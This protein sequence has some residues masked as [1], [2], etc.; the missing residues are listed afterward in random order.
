MEN[1]NEQQKQGQEP[2]AEAKPVMNFDK[3]DIDENKLIAALSYLGL[4]CLIPL[5][6]KKDSKFAQEH[7]K[8]GLVLL[9][10]WMVIWVV[11]IIPIL[12]WI[13]GFI[14]SIVLLIVNLIALVKALMGEF[15][16]IPVLGQYRHQ[17][18]L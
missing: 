4:L 17:F 13:V 7:G 18:K 9:I 15:W 5:L 12:G 11:G 3:K 1:Q 14:G 8:Q 16:E 10:A 6:A 2:P